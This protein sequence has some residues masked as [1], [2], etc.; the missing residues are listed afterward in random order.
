MVWNF[1]ET[2]LGKG[3]PSAV[4][5]TLKRSSQQLVRQG[6]ISLKAVLFDGLICSSIIIKLHF[7][8]AAAMSK[9]YE[10]IKAAWL[11]GVKGTVKSHQVINTTERKLQ[12]R[13]TSC[14]SS[15]GNRVLGCPL[16][17]I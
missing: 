6:Q 11:D 14:G 3:V 12:V 2:G 1:L 10:I 8:D 15:M 7:V 5:G 17:L 9:C 4:S 16:S 13:D